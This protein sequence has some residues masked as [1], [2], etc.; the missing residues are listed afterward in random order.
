MLQP[1]SSK[2]QLEES[3]RMSEASPLVKEDSPILLKEQQQKENERVWT[4]VLSTLVV[5]MMAFMLGCTLGYPS[6]VLLQLENAA[7]PELRFNSVLSGVFGV[8][9]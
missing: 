4:S 2:A 3:K 6:P 5:S 7:E 8:S 1:F 9:C